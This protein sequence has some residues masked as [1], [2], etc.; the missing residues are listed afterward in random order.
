MKRT[1]RRLAREDNSTW[2]SL[3]P[4]ERTIRAAQ[5][6]MQDINAEADKKA[7]RGK[8]Q[9]LKAMQTDARVTAGMA[10]GEKRAHAL[11]EDIE[12]TDGYIR[13]IKDTSLGGLL[14]LIN[15][16]KSGQG[17]SV[18][19]RVSMFLF[20]AENP[21]MS[22]DLLREIYANAD[23]STGNKTARDGA[24]AWLTTI[25]ELRTRFN[26]S[27]GDVGRLEYGYIPH[28]WETHLVR[29][30]GDARAKQTFVDDVLPQLD[31]SRY[32]RED[33][34]AMPDAE[35][36]DFLA[37]A[38]ETLSTNG[39]NKMEVDAFPGT[40][41]RAGR[42]SESREIH[43]RDADA[44]LQTMAKYGGGSMYDVMLGHLGGMARNIGLVE[45]YGP[46]PNSLMRIEF[47]KAAAT[48][49][50]DVS[51]LHRTFGNTPQAYWDMVSGKAATPADANIA[52]IAG[53]ARAIESAGKL[54]A[55]LLSSITDLPL[56]FVTTGFNKLPYFD[57]IRNVTH[58]AADADTR[59]FLTMHGII[60]ESIASDLN[61]W[62]GDSLRGDLPG[63]L[64]N[65]T[66]KLSLLRA[67]T[68]SLRGGF[69]L[70]MQAAMA[71]L[72]KTD[73]Q[74]LTEYDR[75]R[76]ENHGLGEDDW[77][78]IR[79]ATPTQFKGREFMTPQAIRAVDDPRA[80]EVLTK[81]Q[82]MIID[83][84]ETAILNPDL[85]VRTVAS[86]GGSQAG[87]MRGEL[88][89]AVMQFKSFPL[90]IITRHWQRLFDTPA[91][92]EGAP[93]ASNKL[94]YGSALTIAMT[95]LGAIAVQAQ[96]IAAGKDPID[97]TQKKF[98]LAAA[99]K[100][101]GLGFLGDVLLRDSTDDN[102]PQQGLFELL[103]PTFGTVAQAYELT[104]GNIDKSI[105]GKQTHAGAEAL[106][107]ARGHLPFT[108]LWYARAALDHAFLNALSENLS[109]GYL[110][111]MQARAQRE[112]AQQYYWAPDSG[113][114]LKG[115]MSS[116]SRG[117]DL[118]AAIGN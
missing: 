99:T 41:A 79:Q 61:R 87:T 80:V 10:N 71:R 32:L 36:A 62:S 5:R 33:G 51:R 93:L 39:L 46:N 77:N 98:W 37:E 19:R 118:G 8:L 9:I 97:M 56:L 105:A 14:D 73:W 48:D 101:G 16:A 44:Y 1:A 108:N 72:A 75:W 28:A 95:A 109:P 110:G 100:G 24:K 27:G 86:W 115:T 50:R 15:A 96:Q 111:R 103:G 114:L 113:S 35:I 88:A 64:A 94:A 20:D 82:A 76:M 66:Q 68:D 70:T 6:A 85:K 63:K 57:L 7:A 40:G 26:A 23:G 11:V 13:A 89:R 74:A 2:R 59:D 69:S 54:Q 25:E 45:R 91:G 18:A 65:S 47:N 30:K 17:A 52:K 78:L 22:R 92:L 49:L 53:A 58:V 104:K 117:P 3:S 4:E 60:A 38:W 84:S 12:R 106:R 67:W 107:L 83:E 81:Y 55:T 102:S 42:G 29:G 116:P 31:R 43:F 21:Q 34:T 112:F 90:A